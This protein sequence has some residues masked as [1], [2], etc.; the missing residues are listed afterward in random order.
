MIT[1]VGLGNPG[2]EYANTRHNTGRILLQMIAKK[3][4]FSDWRDDK[5]TKALICAGKIGAKK[6]Q[7]VAPDNFMNNSGGSV[8]PFITSKK[9]LE[10]LVVIY[11]DLD[12]PVGRIKISFDRGDGGHNGL[13]SIIKSVKSREFVRIRVGISPET[14]GGKLKKPSGEKL[15]IDFLMKDFKDTEMAEL[16]KIAKRITEALECFAADGK[17]KMMSLYNN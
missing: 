8:K 2:E 17:D 14:P 1:V 12:L 9:D 3:N 11:D 10:S 6:M 5:K 16:K 15:V 7:F 4:D 13:A